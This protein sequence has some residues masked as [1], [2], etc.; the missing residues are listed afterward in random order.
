M[1]EYQT[2]GR[3]ELKGQDLESV[4]DGFVST[5]M[6]DTETLE[7]MAGVYD[8][9]GYLLDPHSAVAVAA[10]EKAAPGLEPGA[11][12]VS[13]ATA[14]PAKFPEAVAEA[15]G[16]ET[17]LPDSARHPSIERS[18]EL[19]QRIRLCDHA[20]LEPA[21]IRAMTRVTDSR[22]GRSRDPEKRG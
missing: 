6:S 8:S 1:K 2:H 20:H 7:T 15:L 10:A 12:I 19:C 18:R 14:H 9:E 5:R 22:S 21:L 17:D 11:K 3:I 4:G 16:P 13:L